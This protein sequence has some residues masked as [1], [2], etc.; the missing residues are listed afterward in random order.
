MMAG[1]IFPPR[2]S[3]ESGYA[4]WNGRRMKCLVTG[5]TGFI[6]SSLCERLQARGVRLERSGREAPAASQI[7]GAAVVFHCAGIAHRAASWEDYETH[8][9]RATL[10]LAR[11]CSEAGVRRFVFLS[12]VIAADPADAYGHWKLR[13]EQELL[14]EHEVS[15][16]RIVVVRPALVYGPGAGGNLERL[17]ELV[18]RGMPAPPGGQ[19]RSMIALADLC[20]ALCLLTEIDP[21]RGRILV[22]TDGESYDLQRIYRAFAGALG[23]KLGPPRFPL[24][25]WWL[26]CHAY[27]LLQLQPVSGKTWQRLFRG[28]LHDNADMCRLLSWQPRYRLEDLAPAMVAE[29]SG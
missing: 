26:A 21:G 8:N 7:E 12:S 24:W 13:T 9:Y 4:I 27:D 3:T 10:A 16:M 14:T 15:P 19:P 18:Q 28:R 2:L 17:I 23:R 20:E 29:F 11:R 1:G 25:C 5:A 22:A 6:G